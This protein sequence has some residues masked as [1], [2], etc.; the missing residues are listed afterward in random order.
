MGETSS[1][2]SS[3]SWTRF[4]P[5]AFGIRQTIEDSPFRWCVRES[6]MW[7]VATGTAM[8]IHRLRMKS[9]PFFAG[10]IAFLTTMIV[11]APSYYFCFRKREH[12]EKVIEMMMAANDFRPG[13]E[14]PETVPLDES[15]PFLS[16]KDD[17]GE[18]GK[19]LKK[20]FVA[21]L[22]EKKEW[23]E[24]HKIQDANEVFQEVTRK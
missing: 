13:E 18:V 3:S 9:H 6:A 11:A 5:E 14:M 17:V 2:E 10:N 24:Q 20:E 12:Q 19:D 23:Q 15:H 21:R 8:G 22:K 1:H 4:L 7:G 16:V